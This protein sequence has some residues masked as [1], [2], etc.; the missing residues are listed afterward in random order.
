[1]SADMVKATL[2]YTGAQ[3]TRHTVQ[4]FGA[5]RCSNWYLLFCAAVCVYPDSSPPAGGIVAGCKGP[6]PHAKSYGNEG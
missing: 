2:R 6:Q 3:P 1:M 5:L 4:G